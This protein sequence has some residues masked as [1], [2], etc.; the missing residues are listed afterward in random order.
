MNKNLKIAIIGSRGYPFIYS[1]Y[2]TLVKELSERLV[3]K[4]HIVRVYCHRS[5]FKEKPR[6]INGIEL[7]YTPSL[8]T[9]YL[10][11]ITNSFFSFMHVCFSKFDVVLVVN[12]SNGP[13][14]FLMK[15]FG[16][17]S[18]INVDG[19]EWMR[20]KWKGL[21][22]TYFKITS[23]LSTIFFD[24]IITDCEEMSKI[25]R[26]KFKKESNIIA[27]GPTTYRPIKN[28]YL[29]NYKLKKNNFYLIVGRMIP[30]NNS[31]LIIDS[32]LAC[33][34]KKKLV[35]VGDVPYDDKYSREIKSYSSEN[36][37][38]T[39]Y[40]RN[41]DE[42]NSLYQNC[43]AYIHGHQYGGTNPT[44][45]NALSLNCQILALN[46][47]FNNEMLEN[48]KAFYFKK[49]KKS[50]INS[51]RLFEKNYNKLIKENKN[52]KL[53]EKYNWNYITKKYLE[54]FFKLTNFQNKSV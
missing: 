9:K 35:V 50:I 37:I 19:L 17:K 14:G 47:V 43:Y 42:L 46:T 34:S 38:L 10:S 51:F 27:Y 1:G 36:L 3:Q 29:K 4:G 41:N 18:C 45:I 2:E 49:N 8:E 11:Q 28:G 13:F 5:L 25:Y 21:G 52:Y 53:P 6:Y 40:I 7:I 22:A 16:I 44:M 39:G 23:R 24:E 30:D 26:N 31:K 12:S 33:R 20:P 32:F 15:I 54:I 48:K